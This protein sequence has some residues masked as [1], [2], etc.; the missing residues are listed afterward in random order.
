MKIPSTLLIIL[1]FVL[2]TGSHC[3]KN[4]P[5]DP[6]TQLPPET[7][8]GANTFGCLINGQVFKPGGAQLSG[9]SLQCTYQFLGSGLNGGFHFRLVGVND[10]SSNRR[11]IGIFTD[12]LEVSQGGT[13][14]LR[15]AHVKSG[16]YGL[17]SFS[18][19]QPLSRDDY[20]TTDISTGVLN[21]KKLDLVNQIMSGTFWF[22]AVNLNG[23]KVEIREGRFD[24]RYTQ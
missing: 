4:K 20:E 7:Q 5:V 19:T 3:K 13:Y 6:I 11:S 22:D 21:I 10:N 12:S 17:Y 2:L 1:T 14:N 8:T 23:Q 9:G 18:T 15:I 24:V 16:A